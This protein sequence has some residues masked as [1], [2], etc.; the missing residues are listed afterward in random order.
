MDALAAMQDAIGQGAQVASASA[1]HPPAAANDVATSSATPAA[2]PGPPAGAADKMC[3][4]W[5]KGFCAR[6]DECWFKHGLVTHASNNR[7]QPRLSPEAPVFQP[8]AT[9]IPPTDTTAGPSSDAILA[10]TEEQPACGICFDETP[11]SY[12]LLGA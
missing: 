12:G 5:A 9:P 8:A 1:P 2:P 11:A 10:A 4:W 7:R 3:K 6:G